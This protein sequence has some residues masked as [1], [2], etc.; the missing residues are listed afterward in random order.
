[1]T[2]MILILL[3]AAV[4]GSLWYLYYKVKKTVGDVSQAAFGTRSLTKGLK[5]QSELLESTPKSVSGMTRI[6]LPQIQADFPE[7][8]W[9]EFRQK[10]ENMLK[11]S[12]MAIDRQNISV[13]SDASEDLKN[14]IS[15]KIQDLQNQDQQEHFEQIKIHQTEITRYHKDR[16]TCI[17][18]LQS[19]LEY[20]H[21]LEDASGEI[22]K[23]AKDRKLQTRYNTELVYIQDIGQAG[24]DKSS[25]AMTCPQCGAPV[26]RLGSKFCE[27]C[28]AGIIE[29]SIRVWSLNKIYEL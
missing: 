19:A 7:F 28:G 29:I 25:L 8:N 2:R 11:A 27:Y 4:L 24:E 23:G 26:T 5:R 16:G 12:L 3:L 10:S 9:P 1:M 18:T 21:R 13:L 6:F 20:Y 17:I 22:L 15:L 14:Q